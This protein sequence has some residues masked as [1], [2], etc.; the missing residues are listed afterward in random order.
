MA[1]QKV[2]LSMIITGVAVPSLATLLAAIP[3]IP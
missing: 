2:F 3:A 1:N